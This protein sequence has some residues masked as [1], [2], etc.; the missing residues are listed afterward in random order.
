[1]KYKESDSKKK[2]SFLKQFMAKL[3]LNVAD[4]ATKLNLSSAQPLYYAFKRDDMMLSM[5]LD[6][7]S[8]YGYDISFGFI[9]DN[10]YLQVDMDLGP[11]Q[12]YSAEDRNRRLF[13]LREMLDNGVNIAELCN[14]LHMAKSTIYY[15]FNHDDCHLSQVVAIAEVVG[16][17]LKIKIRPKRMVVR[18]IK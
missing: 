13:F 3:G 8:A 17:P 6:I 5:L 18:N 16:I 7:F 10:E 15:W 2:L 11:D 14:T 12:K 4:V 9:R 1:M